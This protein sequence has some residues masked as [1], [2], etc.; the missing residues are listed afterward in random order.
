MLSMQCPV[1]MT[2][3][4][5]LLFTPQY[6]GGEAEAIIIGSLIQECLANTV[7]IKAP[8]ACR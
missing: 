3:I 5:H 2:T 6:S 4:Y 8:T 7:V 1:W